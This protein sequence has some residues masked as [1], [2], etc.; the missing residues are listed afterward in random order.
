MINDSLNIC[1]VLRQVDFEKKFQTLPRF[2]PE[3]CQS[4]SA[5]SVPSS[6]RVFSQ[7]YRKKNQPQ[8]QQPPHSAKSCKSSDSKPNIVVWIFFKL[9]RILSLNVDYE[10]EQPPNSAISGLSTATPP[11]VVGNR[12]FGPDFS[13]EQVKGETFL[14]FC[15]CFPNRMLIS[16]MNLSDLNSNET[17]ADRSPRTPVQSASASSTVNARS[18]QEITEKGHR[19]I[20]EQRRQLVMELFNTCGMFPSSKDTTEFQ[21][22]KSIIHFD[23]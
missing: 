13:I 4:P 3:D 17:V 15:Y 16:I 19:K 10:D 12:F 14:S 9:H 23:F 6:P 22:S 2:K 8:L 18:T 20:L 21:V 11:L 1:S 5:I 7:S